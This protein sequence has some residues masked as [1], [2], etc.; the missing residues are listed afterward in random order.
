MEH[1]P[2]EHRP[3]E[4]RPADHRHSTTVTAA[5]TAAAT[6]KLKDEKV[7]VR[8]KKKLCDRDVEEVEG[9]QSVDSN[10]CLHTHDTQPSPRL[11]AETV[12]FLET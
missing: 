11:V 12:L 9:A 4:R 2:I 3:I 8:R 1:R 7:E 5:A 10:P 6:D